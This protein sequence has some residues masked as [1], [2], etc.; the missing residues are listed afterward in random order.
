MGSTSS[1]LGSRPSSSSSSTQRVNNNHRFRFSS[2]LCGAS[3]SRS[4]SQ[5]EGHQYEE[6]QV[7]PARDFDDEIQKVANES[8]LSSAE[9]ARFGCCAQAESSTSTDTGTGLRENATVEGSFGNV[10]TSSQRN[11]LS[12]QKELVPPYQVSAG[13]S[14]PESYSDSN[15]TASTSF[16]EQKSSDSVS[17]SVNDSANKH[18][19]N[20]VDDPVLTG[21]SRISHETTRPRSPIS[22]EYGNSSSG[23]ISVEIN[24]DA[25]ISVHSS[26][27]PVS[28]ASNT[29]PASQVPE[30]GTR[31]ETLP[32]GLGILVS[33]REIV[34]GNDGLFQVDVVAISSNILSGSNADADDHDAR[35]NSRRLFWDAFSQR[36]SRRLGDSPTIVFSSGGADDLGSQDRWHVDF[37]ED[38]SNYGVGGASGHRGS[39]IHRLNER[40]RNSRSEIWERLR[41]GLD[42]IGRL[43]TSCPLGLH[44]DGMCSCES[45]PMAEESSTRS[46]ISR[47][48]MLAEALFEVLDEIHRQPGSQSLS[49]SLPAPE[50]VVDSFPLKFHKKVD[51]ADGGSDAEQCYI[52]L[53][54]YEDG[55]QIRVLPCKHEYHMLC[56]DKW[57]KEIHGVCP[58]CRSN[59]CGG[60]TELSTDSEVQSR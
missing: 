38:L 8:T 30:D 35:R 4:I 51:A 45:F 23:E 28:Q 56:V 32:S 17:L 33:N 57:L 50:S 36:S 24:T 12:E 16:V 34:H 18:R 21:V 25:G 7:D 52:C 48:V 41:G 44:A 37:D 60:L 59:V 27:I 40:V 43:N 26:S 14:H 39:R 5:M 10:A 22:Q 42:E 54:E 11:C 58:L 55:D 3:T 31:H 13:H 20:N 46:S 29:L 15:N 6:L 9:E 47:I 49:T 19:I 1:R 2:F 53:A